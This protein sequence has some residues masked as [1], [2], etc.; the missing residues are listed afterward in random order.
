MKNKCIHLIFLLLAVLFVA[1]EK[2]EEEVIDGNLAPPDTTIEHVVFENY[3]NKLYI[4]LL[5]RKASS[6]EHETG[7]ALLQENDLAV[8]ARKELVATI[9]SD[10]LYPVREYEIARATL[11]NSIDTLEIRNWINIIDQQL[12]MVANEE[13]SLSLIAAREKVEPLL[14]IP[15]DLRA[16]DITMIQMHKYCVD[17][18]LYDEINMGTENFIV[19]MFQSFLYRYP[20]TVELEEATK[21]VDGIQ[22]VVFYEIGESKQDFI[23]IFM[24]SNNY[25]EGQVRDLYERYLFREPTPEEASDLANQYKNEGSFRAIQSEILTSD[26]YV[27]L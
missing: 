5:G 18:F 9:Q 3:V 26:E 1:C 22:G 25:Y 23:D 12:M 7:L 24:A 16:G 8:S 2:T 10:E 13:D 27:G 21:V 17:N 15:E 4:S 6:E 20:S 11:L 14:T 19:S